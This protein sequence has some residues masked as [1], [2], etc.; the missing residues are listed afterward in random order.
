MVGDGGGSEVGWGRWSLG[1]WEKIFPIFIFYSFTY[2]YIFLFYEFKGN[3]G[4]LM[5]SNRIFEQI[6]EAKI[7][8]K[9]EE[10]KIAKRDERLGTKCII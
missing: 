6:F 2:K 10:G 7:L 8:I 3:Y 9:K 1:G 4:I 5:P